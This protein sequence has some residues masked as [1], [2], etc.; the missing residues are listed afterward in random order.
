M[1]LITPEQ[2]EALVEKGKTLGEW[3]VEKEKG[4]AVEARNVEQRMLDALAVLALLLFN[5]V[6]WMGFGW[7]VLRIVRS[8]L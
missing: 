8:L 4:K 2:A 3:L 5:L 1:D 7:I 6:V